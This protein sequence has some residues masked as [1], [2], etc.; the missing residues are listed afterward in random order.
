MTVKVLG[1]DEG[2]PLLSTSSVTLA[3]TVLYPG[4]SPRH[5]KMKPSNMGIQSFSGRERMEELNGAHVSVC[6]GW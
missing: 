4:P 1:L 2:E 5:P 6:V 3:H